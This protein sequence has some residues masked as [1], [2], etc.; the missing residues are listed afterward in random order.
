MAS[1][2]VSGVSCRLRFPERDVSLFAV[3]VRFLGATVGTALDAADVLPCGVLV[4]GGALCASEGVEVAVRIVL[5]VLEALDASAGAAGGS[6]NDI[7]KIE[8]AAEP[9]GCPVLDRN[10]PARA[11]DQVRFS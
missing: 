10:N 6:L 7:Q 1:F 8:D 2:H 5:I 4:V 11:V 9:R 3:D